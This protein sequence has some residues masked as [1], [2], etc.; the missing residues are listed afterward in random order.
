VP[1]STSPGRVVPASHIPGTVV[2]VSPTSALLD[3]VAAASARALGS[4]RNGTALEP[5]AFAENV[6]GERAF[7]WFAAES[8]V[9]GRAGARAAVA[10][11]G[12]GVHR[13]VV[14]YEGEAVI[15]GER[16]DALYLEAHERGQPTILIAQRFARRR[17]GA[18]PLG[19]LALC[20]VG[21]PLLRA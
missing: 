4:L 3:L 8:P 21:D 13:V 11:L 19:D 17:R 18:R 16:F 6:R 14:G 9:E 20:G 1:P 10:R 15:D 5:F 7:E 2:H 12:R